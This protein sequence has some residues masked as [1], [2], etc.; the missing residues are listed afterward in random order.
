MKMLQKTVVRSTNQSALSIRTSPEIM[1]TYM[2]INSSQLGEYD[3]F[4]SDVKP[5][6]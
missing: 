4:I 2:K 1:T 5:L 6:K 3:P